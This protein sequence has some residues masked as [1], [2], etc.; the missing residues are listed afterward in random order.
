MGGVMS[1]TIALISAAVAVF[2]AL[3]AA[4]TSR[5]VA[6][7]QAQSARELTELKN[8]F[9][10][11]TRTR[12]KADKLEVIVSRYR[13][14]LARTAFDLQSRIYNIIQQAFLTF[15]YKRD[16]S[17][18]EY[19]EQ[20]TLYVVSEYLGWA[21]LL[22]RELEFLDLGDL[23]R[24]MELTVALRSIDRAFASDVDYWD[25]RFRLFRGEQRAIGEKMLTESF[26]I[27]GVK[28]QRPMGY[29]SFIEHLKE[30]SF[31]LWYRHLREGIC[32]LAEDATPNYGRLVHLQHALVDLI[33]LLDDPPRRFPE[34][35]ITKL[36]AT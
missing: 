8:E 24:S 11:Q 19:V 21:E 31:A 22:R 1:V 15:Y 25:T 18:R 12:D 32:E 28:S 20:N 13:E 5:G 35:E 14:P 4:W 9:D 10:A 30:P 34:G 33:K 36:P 26:T 27:D 17:E 3:W 2:G 16:G 23:E 7:Q 29:A 6:R